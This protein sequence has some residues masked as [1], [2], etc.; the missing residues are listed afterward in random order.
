MLFN[1]QVVE[2]TVKEVTWGKSKDKYLKP[3]IKI[4]PPIKLGG[5]TITFATAFNAKY[6]C[7]NKLG[8]GAKIKITRSG[9]VIPYITS[10]VKKASKPQMPSEKYYWNETET[11]IILDSDDDLE[12]KIKKI[13]Y[14]FKILKAKGSK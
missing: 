7:D 13:S 3:R 12:V 5:V 6:V 10:I 9:D 4:D 11:D 14:F 1:D 2:A 8:P